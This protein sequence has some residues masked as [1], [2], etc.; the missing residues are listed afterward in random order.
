MDGRSLLLGVTAVGYTQ[1]LPAQQSAVR[2]CAAGEGARSVAML[3]LH[4]GV[5]H[6]CRE[7][8]RQAKQQRDETRQRWPGWQRNPHGI[9]S[10]CGKRWRLQHDL[11]LLVPFKK[12]VTLG[13]RNPHP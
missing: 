4:V 7:S 2:R 9:V 13:S 12:L 8:D 1:W 10:L 11:F 5:G 3:R 6:H